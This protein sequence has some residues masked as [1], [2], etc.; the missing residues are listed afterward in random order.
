MAWTCQTCG[1]EKTDHDMWQTYNDLDFQAYRV[2]ED[3]SPFVKGAIARA[4]AVL[5]EQN[6]LTL[7]EHGAPV[8]V[9]LPE[10]RF[11]KPPG[12]FELF[13][14][15]LDQAMC[16]LVYYVKYGYKPYQ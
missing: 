12:Y 11:P 2:C 14:D 4:I 13:M 6:G 9:P 10:G 15:K 16:N 3:C 5:R 1:D 7:Y 8:N